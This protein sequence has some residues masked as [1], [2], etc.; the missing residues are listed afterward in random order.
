MLGYLFGRKAK[1][2]AD[3]FGEPA[4][5]KSERA[6]AEKTGDD[7]PTAHEA[8]EEKEEDEKEASATGGAMT[9]DAVS[10]SSSSGA[11]RTPN[12]THIS[13]SF[14]KRTGGTAR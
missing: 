12:P 5:L 4:R 7:H 6:E 11:P 2:Q 14:L 13:A 9:T 10:A 1:G 8:K 3:A